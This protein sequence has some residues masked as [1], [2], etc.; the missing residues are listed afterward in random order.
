MSLKSSGLPN[1]LN[2]ITV[3]RGWY[4]DASLGHSW[5]SGVSAKIPQRHGAR[6]G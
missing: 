3:N 1:L 4:T 5:F 6:A 2:E